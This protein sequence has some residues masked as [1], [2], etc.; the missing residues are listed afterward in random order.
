MTWRTVAASVIGTSHVLTGEACQDSCW[1]SVDT[2]AN[3]LEMLSLFISDGAGSALRGGVGAETAVETAAQFVSAK[4]SAPEFTL[5]DELAVECAMAVRDRIYLLAENEGLKARDFACTF[6]GVLSS[7]QG[8]LILQ[9]GDGAVV[10][11]VGNGLEV[12]VAPMM[13]EYANMT[14]FITDEDAIDV[15]VSRF[16]DSRVMR[17]AAFSDG[18]Q[19]LAL[20]MA[21]STPFD[22]FFRPLFDALTSATLDQT[23]ELHCALLSFLN[24]NRVNELTDDDKSLAIAVFAD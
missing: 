1:V 2:D 20:N 14:R 16:F 13:G 22:P 11:D 23:D 19:R 7:S 10:V 24:S 3:G 18:L 15:I 6:L 9:I 17:V 8:T 21:E 12:A 5:C 4:L